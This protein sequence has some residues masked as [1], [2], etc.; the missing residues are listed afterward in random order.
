MLYVF[1]GGYVANSHCKCMYLL[2]FSLFSMRSAFAGMTFMLFLQRCCARLILTLVPPRL[3]ITT[4]YYVSKSRFRLLACLSSFPHEPTTF[5][6]IFLRTPHSLFL[7]LS[8]FFPSFL[9]VFSCQN[10]TGGVLSWTLVHIFCLDIFGDYIFC[11][12][13]HSFSILP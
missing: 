12:V 1:L 4:W 10:R 11:T 13:I 5:Y 9:Y 3:V 8:F 6:S 2:C 7:F